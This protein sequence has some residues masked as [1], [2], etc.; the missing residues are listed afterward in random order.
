MEHFT[1]NYFT[2]DSFV[3][4]A[5]NFDS[6]SM[7]SILNALGNLKIKPKLS[8]NLTKIIIRQ[9]YERKINGVHKQQSSVK[10]GLQVPTRNHPDFPSIYFMHI[11]CGGYFHSRLNKNIRER[12]GLT[13]YIATALETSAQA[14]IFYI[15]AE[16]ASKQVPKLLTQVSKELTRM[17]G[18]PLR[19]AEMTMIRNYI[20]GNMIQFY[21]ETFAKAETL[22]QQ[23]IEGA[24]WSSGYTLMK[25]ISQMKAGDLNDK[26]K[27]YLLVEKMITII[28]E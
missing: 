13:Y 5:G 27:E 22:R 19:G 15:T 26:I 25:Q 21:D 16:T 20:I 8:F 24:Q 14:G 7:Q 3:I 6:Q 12:Q 23:L 17:I 2:T 11:L 9:G 1:Q 10:M 4:L 28:A 18:Q